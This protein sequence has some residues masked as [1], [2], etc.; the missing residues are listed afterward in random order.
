M[1]NPSVYLAL[2]KDCMRKILLIALFISR[3]NISSAQINARDDSAF[4]YHPSLLKEIDST[5]FLEKKNDVEFQLWIS[6]PKMISTRLFILTQ[7]DDKWVARLFE[8]N[9]KADTL[10]EITIN[11]W[12]LEKLWQRLNDN[13]ILSIPEEEDLKD[14]NGKEIDLLIHHGTRYSFVLTSTAAN[15]S[16]SYYCPKLHLKEYK[17]VK[18]FARV[19][20]IISLVFKHCGI[21]QNYIC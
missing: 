15:R 1:V 6:H 5:F 14:K 3:V 13:K 20:N 18:T 4:Q 16:Y 10:V 12:G 9:Y 19:F 8:K 21:K 11:Q 7:K 2:F 17:Y